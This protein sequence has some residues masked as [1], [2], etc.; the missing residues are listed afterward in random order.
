[1]DNEDKEF[2]CK[3]GLAAEGEFLVSS[4]IKGWGLCFNPLKSDDPYTH[5]Y[6][7]MCQIDIKTI[8]TQWRDFRR[9]GKLYPN[10]LIL[11]N[12]TWQNS[13][14]LLTI[15]RARRL[16]MEGKAKMHSYQNRV[17]DTKGNAKDSYIFDTADLDRLNV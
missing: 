14:Y 11:C 6:F 13:V 15:D 2:W 12:V 10:I 16:V 4:G 9:Y 3:A 8:K 5:D 17:N 7:G 1:V